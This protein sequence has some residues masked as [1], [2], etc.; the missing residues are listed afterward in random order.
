[1]LFEANLKLS[2]LMELSIAIERPSPTHTVLTSPSV[3]SSNHK[4]KPFRAELETFILNHQE[5]D[6]SSPTSK[7]H[8][9]SKVVHARKK[10]PLKF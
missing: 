2:K 4:R 9:A 7:D 1:M 5:H 8:A 6:E 3:F 10:F